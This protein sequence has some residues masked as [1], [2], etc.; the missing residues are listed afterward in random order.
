[1][2]SRINVNYLIDLLSGSCIARVKISRSVRA[3]APQDSRVN[4]VIYEFQG[5]VYLSMPISSTDWR[6]TYQA[7]VGLAGGIVQG[8]TSKNPIV[9]MAGAA[10][11]GAA[12]AI[13]SEKVSPSL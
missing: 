9:G 8:A 12:D 13:M 3:T 2:G 5:N 1:M 11:T 10:A 6:G 4:D 7:L